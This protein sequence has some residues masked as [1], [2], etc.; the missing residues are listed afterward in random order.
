MSEASMTE[1]DAD[2]VFGTTEK[3]KRELRK[4]SKLLSEKERGVTFVTEGPRR[5][6]MLARPQMPRKQ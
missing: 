6:A 2:E 5:G 1:E 4:A 3:H